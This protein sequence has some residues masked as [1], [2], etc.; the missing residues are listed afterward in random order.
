MMTSPR[1]QRIGPLATIA[2]IA[3]LTVLVG[4]GVGLGVGLV[5][6]GSSLSTCLA[7]CKRS[8]LSVTNR[9]TCRLDCEVDAASDPELI[10]AQTPPLR[11]PVPR[12]ESRPTPAPSHVSAPPRPQPPGPAGTIA[13]AS[14]P[15]CK[16]ACDA[17]TALSLDDRATCKLECDLV[18]DPFPTGTP[19]PMRPPPADALASVH[20]TASTPTTPGPQVVAA[21]TRSAADQ[22]DQPGFLNRCHAT[23]KPGH[24]ERAATDHESCKLDCDNMASVLDLA[25]TWIPEAWDGRPAGVPILAAAAPVVPAAVPPPVRTPRTSA[26]RSEPAPSL[27]A[28]CGPTLERCR[29]TCVKTET[30]CTR[31]CGRKHVIETD[32]ETCKLGCGTDQEVCQGDCLTATATCVNASNPR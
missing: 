2:T 10:R 16:P 19:P 32:R 31:A 9:A 26:P 28:T 18:P 4:L 14:D 5:Q 1:F 21:G 17:N 11:P 7:E 8:H 15:D 23:C 29:A 27:R 22:P 6:A 20:A 3:A 25:S 13:R 12:P 30:R 24:D